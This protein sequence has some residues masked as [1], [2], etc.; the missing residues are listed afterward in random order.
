[1]VG[2]SY[3][4][5]DGVYFDWNDPV[6]ALPQAARAAGLRPE[7]ASP[8]QQ[9]SI[10]NAEENAESTAQLGALYREIQAAEYGC[11]VMVCTY[12]HDGNCWCFNTALALHVAKAKG[13]N[14]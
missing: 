13:E 7:P 3:G 5:G 1:M 2:Y 14:Q 11:L 12:P 9:S 10:P 4:L 6:T 8:S